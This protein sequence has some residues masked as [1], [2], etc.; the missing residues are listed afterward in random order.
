MDNPRYCHFG[1]YW[2][3]S[4]H[5]SNRETGPAVITNG[6]DVYFK[7]TAMHRSRKSGPC[8]VRASGILTYAI[9]GDLHRTTGPAIIFD[10]G[11]DEHWVNGE[12]IDRLDFF[13]TFGTI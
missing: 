1:V 7:N 9:D 5:L 4:V 12:K 13:L 8:S 10:N 3:K 2:G 11:E 6:G